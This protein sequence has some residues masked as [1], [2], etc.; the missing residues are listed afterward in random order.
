MTPAD[1]R[2]ALAI[3]GLSVEQAGVWL[4]VSRRTAYNYASEGPTP[5][6]ARAV[7]M[8]LDMTPEDRE[9]ALR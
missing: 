3:L 9:R 5:P 1:Y 6:A 8:L 4:G 7:R 2:A